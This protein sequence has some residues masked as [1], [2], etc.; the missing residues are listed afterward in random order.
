MLLW[1]ENVQAIEFDK[2]IKDIHYFPTK[3]IAHD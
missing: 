2:D 1:E 3:D